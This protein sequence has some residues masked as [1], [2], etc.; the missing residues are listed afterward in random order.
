MKPGPTEL[1]GQGG[2]FLNIS[3]DMCNLHRAGWSLNL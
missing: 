1:I 2:G 3:R